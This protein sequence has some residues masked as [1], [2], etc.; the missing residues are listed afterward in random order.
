MP[1]LAHLCGRPCR[2]CERTSQ[3]SL[4][5]SSPVE[6]RTG[7][8]IFR[9]DHRMF[10]THKREKKLSLAW[11]SALFILAG[12]WFSGALP[13]A[14]TGHLPLYFAGDSQPR[15]CVA[16]CHQLI[17]ETLCSRGNRHG[18]YHRHIVLVERL[19]H[20]QR[21]RTRAAHESDWRPAAVPGR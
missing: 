9:T 20:D 18:S 11:S 4:V 13:Q 5:T 17:I 21:Q 12:F 8:T 16:V 19:N 10:Y 7:E 1:L 15:I 6:N 2:I 3:A 14:L